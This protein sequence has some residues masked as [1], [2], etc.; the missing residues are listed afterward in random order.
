M[1]NSRHIAGFTGRV[2]RYLHAFGYVLIATLMGASFL[3]TATA[4]TNDVQDRVENIAALASS[5]LMLTV[6]EGPFIMG[7]ARTS[8]EPFSFDLQ[9]DDT[10]QPQRRVWLH[11]Y[12]IDRDEVSL[13][14]YLL[15]LRQQQRHLPEEVRKL[16][17][18]VTTIHAL[19]LETLAR[20]PALYV[21]WSEASDFCHTRDKRLPTEA[22]WEKAAR[23]DSGNLFPWGQRPPTPALAMFGQYHVHEIP[24]VASVDSGVEGRSPYGLH[25]MAGN[26][27][28]WVEDWFGIDYYATMPDRNPHG[29]AGGR[30]KVVRGGSWKSAPALLRTA[31]R[32]GAT[33]DQR[34]ATIGFRCARSAR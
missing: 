31:T 1:Q 22:E 7:T 5:P 4:A 30:Y 26:A 9:Y 20:W 17:D 33:P 21:T 10:E 27:A 6:A 23:G 12:E 11:Q 24:V 15:W 34:A 8:H 3:R 29:P 32:G 2:R 14:E 13:G 16:I 28:E 18:H 25:H 19:P